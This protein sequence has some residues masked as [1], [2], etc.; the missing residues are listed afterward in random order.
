MSGTRVAL[1]ASERALV[2]RALRHP[3]GRYS[4]DRASQLSAI[5]VRTLHDW[6]TSG[7]LVPDWMTARPRG[8]S[9]RDV[10]YARLLAWLRSKH[11]DR[12]TAAQRVAFVRNRL[13]TSPVDPAVRSDGSIVL[14]GDDIV[15]HVSGQQVFDGVAE[16]LDVFELTDPVEGVSTDDL[17]GPS[18]VHPSAHTFISPW[19]LGGEPCIVH[20][21]MPSGSLHAL[22]VD[23]GLDVDE[24]RRLYPFLSSDAI[25]DALELE[26]R[27]RAA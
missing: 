27:L 20:S 13:S 8:W 26:R 10:I 22:H 15:D 5:P 1:T 25:E 24:I 6:A 17:W 16:L 19:V 4:A 12:A 2:L 21:R 14:I 23:R 7:A 3:R 11:M 18:L 9:Y